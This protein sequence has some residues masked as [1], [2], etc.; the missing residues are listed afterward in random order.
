MTAARVASGFREDRHDVV[1]IS[2][3]ASARV[4]QAGERCEQQEN[5][6]LAF[7]GA[8]ATSR[9]SRRNNGPRA[10]ARRNLVLK[11]VRPRLEMPPKVPNLVRSMFHLLLVLCAALALLPV[12]SGQ[13]P[14]S[15]LQPVAATTKADLPLPGRPQP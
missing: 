2:D 14:V 11:T 6:E 3:L 7:H 5:G 9:E 10:N 13:Q 1:P 15:R 4:S 12:A 8:A